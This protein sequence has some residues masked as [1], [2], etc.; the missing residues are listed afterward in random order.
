MNIKKVFI[1]IMLTV[2]MT[3]CWFIDFE[4]VSNEKEYSYLI[5]KKFTTLTDLQINGATLERNYKKQIDVY[6]VNV[7]PGFSGS[8]VV[9]SGRLPAGTEFQI[10]KVMRCTNCPFE[11]RLEIIIDI[12]TNDKHDNAPVGMSYN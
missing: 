10:S 7:F 5:G 12:L 11:T 6:I 8:E 1:L 9:C 3:G 2:S 4:D